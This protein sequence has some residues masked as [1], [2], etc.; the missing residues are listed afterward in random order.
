MAEKG[1][2]WEVLGRSVRWDEVMRHAPQIV[3]AARILYE[4]N[5]QRQQQR[6]ESRPGPGPDPTTGLTARLADLEGQVRRLQENETQQSALVADMAKQ[7]NALTGSVDAL[8][9]RVQTL[10]WVSA[11]ALAAG[12]AALVTALV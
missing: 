12:L 10:L 11:A 3:D 2:I 4:K 8:A 6:P 1:R 9:R 7:I 5:R